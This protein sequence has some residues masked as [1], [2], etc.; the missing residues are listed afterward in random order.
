MLKRRPAKGRFFVAV[1]PQRRKERRALVVTQAKAE[2]SIIE[3]VAGHYEAEEIPFGIVYRWCPESLRIEC[4]CSKVLTLTRSL[5]TCGECG[6][7]HAPIVREELADNRCS[8]DEA[9]HPWRYAGDREGLG[10]PC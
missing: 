1:E 3:G 4:E 8:E 7:D 6:A 10:L 2:S 9:L 5:T